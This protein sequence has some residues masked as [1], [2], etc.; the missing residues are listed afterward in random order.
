MKEHFFY[1]LI[2]A[3]VHVGIGVKT[4]GLVLGYPETEVK[5]WVQEKGAPLPEIRN[6]LYLKLSQ[7]IQVSPRHQKRI[8]DYYFN[9]IG[10]KSLDEVQSE[11]KSEFIPGDDYWVGKQLVAFYYENHNVGIETSIPTGTVVTYVGLS[12]NGMHCVSYKDPYLAMN[13]LVWVPLLP[14]VGD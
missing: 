6:Q 8:S 1:T 14:V 2:K 7:F 4:I 13:I 9:S 3:L 5:C 12:T 10:N 11:Q